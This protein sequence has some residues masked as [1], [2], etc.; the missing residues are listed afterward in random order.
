[1]RLGVRALIRCCDVGVCPAPSA[2]IFPFTFLTSLLQAGCATRA[3]S[4][5][6]EV[7]ALFVGPSIDMTRSNAQ[8]SV[9]HRL[10]AN[11]L[12][13]GAIFH[14][15]IC[16]PIPGPRTTPLRLKCPLDLSFLSLRLGILAFSCT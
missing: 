12:S 10:V 16:H 11:A 9:L 1:M 6:S 7:Q 2:T 5:A 13:A 4:S 15:V 8:F 3:G 14:W